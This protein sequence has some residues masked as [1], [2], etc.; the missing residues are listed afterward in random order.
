MGV[1]RERRGWLRCVALV[2]AASSAAFGGQSL[3]VASNTIGTFTVPA[4]SPFTSLGSTRLEMR[5]HNFVFPSS[6]SQVLMDLGGGIQVQLRASQEICARDLKD[7]LPDYGDVV[8]LNGSGRT[9][10]T[11][12]VQRD[13]ETKRFHIEAWNSAGGGYV[14]GYCNNPGS[15][16]TGCPIATVGTSSWA[17]PGTIGSA[18]TLSARVAWVKWH[19]T[20]TDLNGRV[21][22]SYDSADLADWRFEGNLVDQGPFGINISISFGATFEATPMYPP[23]SAPRG[24]GNPGWMDWAPMRA[25]FP[26]QLDGTFSYSV[27]DDPLLTYFWQQIDGPTRLIWSSRTVAQPAV[28]G[29]VFGTYVVRLTVTDTTGQRSHKDVEIAAA[30]S[31]EN[32]VVVYGSADTGKIF[33]PMIRFGAN[34]WPWADNRHKALADFFGGLLMAGDPQYQPYWDTPVGAGTISVT[35]GSTTIVGTATTFLTTFNCNG[36]DAI[37]V[38]YRTPGGTGRRVFGI[39]S[40]QSDTALTISAPYDAGV[41][42]SGLTYGRQTEADIGSWYGNAT[43]NNFY[44]NVMAHYSLYYRSGHTR[45]RDFARMLA[46]LWFRGPYMDEGRCGYCLIPRNRAITGLVAR[47]LDGRPEIL[48][49]LRTLWNNDSVIISG[50]GWP[51]DTREEAYRMHSFGLAAL[52][53]PIPENRTTYQ[54]WLLSGLNGRWL[55]ALGPQGNVPSPTIDFGPGTVSV[56]NGSTI[57][58]GTGTNF[59]AATCA[60]GRYVWFASSLTQGDSVA[61]TCTYQAPEQ[62]TLDRP[63]EGESATGKLW[64]SATLVGRGTQPFIMGIVGNAMQLLNVAT[65]NED[66]GE[67]VLKLGN[68]L[69]RVGYWE[70]KK[71]LFYGREFVNC[72]PNPAVVTN[73]ADA[74]D[75]D[76]AARAFAGEVFGLLSWMYLRNGDVDAKLIAD[77][78]MGGNFG[79][80]GFGGP[81]T[82]EGWYNVQLDDG[83]IVMTT[84]KA[85]DYAFF[86]GFGLA[87]TW[88]A[89]RLG[90]VKP[91]DTLTGWVDF[92]LSTINGAA[93]AQITVTQPSGAVQEYS[94]TSS[95]C[96]IQVDRRQGDHWVS[97]EYRNASGTP[98]GPRPDPWLLEV[99]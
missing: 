84:R 87:S 25:G 57:V 49:G 92:D 59:S 43:N 27:S 12:R 50:S 7:S 85:K 26:G 38:W 82:A 56:T 39:S 76:V 75:G 80:P 99:N 4:V 14:I 17:G 11:L 40:C 71:G 79:K 9:H 20:K 1:M 23:V 15:A 63:Y 37:L 88:P 89:A 21:A 68:W 90:G 3:V 78:L 42:E 61:Y 28:K 72:E 91:A 54:Q 74:G 95:P 60:A 2:W 5:V 53:D 55:P 47:A 97:V 29:L 34:P 83:G 98:V 16:Q 65:G 30:A 33:G 93:S 81:Q 8:C 10:V 45:Y 35:A 64:Q 44:D 32:G 6:G 18:G 36:T 94:C 70:T 69:N 22:Q 66:A 41:T 48:E 86:F 73:C 96:Q 62:I 13:V 31:D 58:T 52:F 46:D 77:S 24:L 19:A 51:G 67:Y